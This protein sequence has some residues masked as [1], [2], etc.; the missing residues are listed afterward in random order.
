[1]LVECTPSKLANEYEYRSPS[2]N[3]LEPVLNGLRKVWH[4]VAPQNVIKSG[5]VS[6]HFQG[7]PRQV[8]RPND[9]WVL[10]GAGRL[11]YALDQQAAVPT[12]AGEV[13]LE[14]VRTEQ[15]EKRLVLQSS[16]SNPA[17]CLAVPNYVYLD[18][19]PDLLPESL[20][21]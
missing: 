20:R 3:K 1:M 16:E 19:A 2:P 5:R 17:N 11:I 21:Q 4:L 7:A 15:L 13:Q 12:V 9:V 10:A 18:S 6:A 8:E 14:I